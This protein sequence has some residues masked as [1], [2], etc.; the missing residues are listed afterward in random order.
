MG[1]PA[2]VEDEDEDVFLAAGEDWCCWAR[3]VFRA[4]S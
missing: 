3:D 2:V 4:G 1:P